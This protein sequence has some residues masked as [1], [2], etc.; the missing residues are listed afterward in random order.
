MS[1]TGRPAPRGRPPG[2][3][4]A[5]AVG[6]DAVSWV[7]LHACGPPS[8]AVPGR[9]RRGRSTGTVRRQAARPESPAPG[10]SVRQASLRRGP[11]GSV[12]R[13][14]TLAGNRADAGIG[15]APRRPAA[16]PFA[17]TR[18]AARAWAAFRAGI[19]LRGARPRDASLPASSAWSR[20]RGVR[21]PLSPR[22][23][24]LSSGLPRPSSYCPRARHSTSGTPARR[25]HQR[26]MTNNR[27]ARRLR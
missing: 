1:A 25:L 7:F 22:S 20:L 19:Q 26:A 21:P 3:T 4:A 11:G 13:E 24:R 15:C 2:R 16:P 5:R 17:C 27:S 14:R 8:C 18:S 10:T 6:D 23:P 12:P 9:V